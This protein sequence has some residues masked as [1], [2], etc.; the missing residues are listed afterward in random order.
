MSRRVNDFDHLLDLEPSDFQ[1]SELL[2]VLDAIGGEARELGLRISNARSEKTLPEEQEGQTVEG[3]DLLS[4]LMRQKSFN[5]KQWWLLDELF[6]RGFDPNILSDQHSPLMRALLRSQRDPLKPALIRY[7]LNKGANPRLASETHN[8]SALHFS[9]G[10]WDLESMRELISHGADPHYVNAAGETPL[11]WFVTPGLQ[12]NSQEIITAK[13]LAIFQFF[14]EHGT[15]FNHR[16][17]RQRSA[18]HHTALQCSESIS[19]FMMDQLL[20]RGVPLKAVDRNQK[21]ALQSLIHFMDEKRPRPLTFKHL[22][23]LER[24]FDERQE[25]TT[26]L[27]LPSLKRNK[28]VDPLGSMEPIKKKIPKGL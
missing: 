5:H 7:L 15:H 6:R 8:T 9:A 25:L 23:T 2:L 19:C 14:D 21:T 16:N 26:L 4:L 27:S 22:S 24:A 11:F 1:R 12:M 13:C 10:L 18:L 28:E 20:L 17:T 3:A